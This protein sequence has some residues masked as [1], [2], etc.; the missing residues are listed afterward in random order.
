ML[1]MQYG[2]T[3]QTPTVHH[4]TAIWEKQKLL[5]ELTCD[6]GHQ[7]PPAV[8]TPEAPTTAA[9]GTAGQ[10]TCQYGGAY[11]RSPHARQPPGHPLLQHWSRG[12]KRGSTHEGENLDPRPQ[13]QAEDLE[14]T[15]QRS[16]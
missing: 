2:Q 7:P 3:M 10:A 13:G 8:V 5:N 6:F 14:G 1:S 9:A 16:S 15:R 4:S 11:R 12:H